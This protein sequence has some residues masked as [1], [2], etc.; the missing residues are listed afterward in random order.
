MAFEIPVICGMCGKRMGE[1]TCENSK[2]KFL[3]PDEKEEFTVEEVLKAIAKSFKLITHEAKGDEHQ[4]Q[5]TER[6]LQLLELRIDLLMQVNTVAARARDI[7]KAD[8][9]VLKGM[10]DLHVLAQ[11]ARAQGFDSISSLGL[12]EQRS[13][14][15]GESNVLDSF[16]ASKFGEN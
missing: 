12:L 4:T 3:L 15:R 14:T 11:E 1:C 8:S 5:I 13:K 9:T 16:I 2:Y 7:D 6:M 10:M